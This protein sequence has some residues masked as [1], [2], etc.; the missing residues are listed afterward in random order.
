[1]RDQG[2]VNPTFNSKLQEVRTTLLPDVISAWDIL[3]PDTR[4]TISEMNNFF[5]KMHLLV[6]FASEADKCLMLFESNVVL[7]GR[8]PYSYQTGSGAARLVRSVSQALT[9][10]GSQTAG[11]ASLFDAY[12]ATN[13]KKSHLIT[14]HGHRF[15]HIFYS[16]AATYF[17]ISDILTFLQSLSDP[18]DLIKCVLFDIQE[19]VYIAG[20]RALGIIDKI[21]TGPF[22]R[23]IEGSKSILDLNNPHLKLLQEMWI[24]WSSDASG[25]MLGNPLFPETVVS[26]HKDQLYDS[27]FQVSEDPTLDT[28]TQMCLELCLNGMLLIIERQAKDQLSGGKYSN[29]ADDSTLHE[30]CKNVPTTKTCSERDFAV[31][32]ILMRMKPAATNLV[33]EAVIMWSNNQTT[34]WL[35]QLPPADK[36]TLLEQARINAP[37][38]KQQFKVREKKYFSRDWIT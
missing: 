20:I 14:F 29:V 6:N 38:V 11:V 30:E 17:H 34:Q 1:M 24:L 26:I 33:Y 19:K 36:A 32:G 22:W 3:S 16:S 7:E 2:S 21:I 13:G 8:N 4:N 31:L 9:R 18:N 35:N 12:M 15:N 23:L 27:L 25:L 37:N 5:C 10:H 28:Y